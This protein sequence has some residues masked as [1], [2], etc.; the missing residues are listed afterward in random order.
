MR[1]Q[2]DYYEQQCL[3]VGPLWG[4][5]DEELIGMI[6]SARVE[7]ARGIQLKLANGSNQPSD[8]TARTASILG[9]PSKS[10]PL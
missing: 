4:H 7:H 2:A 3:E 5:I 8:C 1:E 6:M 10:S 9:E